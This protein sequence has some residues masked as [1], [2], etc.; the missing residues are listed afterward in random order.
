M[1]VK[2]DKSALDHGWTPFEEVECT[3]RSCCSG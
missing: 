2:A 1:H 3:H